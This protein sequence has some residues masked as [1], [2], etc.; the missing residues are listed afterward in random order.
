MAKI[1]FVEQPEKVKQ[2]EEVRRCLLTGL[3]AFHHLISRSE[4]TKEETTQVIKH[5]EIPIDKLYIILLELQ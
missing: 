4:L 5:H 1:G 2:V 3:I